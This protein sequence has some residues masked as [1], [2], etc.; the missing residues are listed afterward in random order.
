MCNV[1]TEG[2]E[3]AENGMQ[4]HISHTRRAFMDF[5]KYL[6]LFVVN[7][8]HKLTPIYILLQS[9]PTVSSVLEVPM[10]WT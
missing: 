5:F 10:D 3:R 1:L 9:R 2:L 8:C 4:V 6:A 7:H